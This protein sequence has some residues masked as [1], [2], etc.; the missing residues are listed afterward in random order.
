MD[1]SEITLA[2]FAL[3]MFIPVVLFL[4]IVVVSMIAKAVLV[5]G[6]W[7]SMYFLER[8]TQVKDPKESIVFTLT[9]WL[10]SVVAAI[11]STA[12]KIVEVV[13]NAT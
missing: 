8:A 4:M 7:F 12:V 11:L 10:F 1:A 2:L 5:P 13:T 3:T 6:K 9:G